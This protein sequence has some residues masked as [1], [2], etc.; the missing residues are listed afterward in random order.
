MDRRSVGRNLLDEAVFA[1]GLDDRAAEAL[2]GECHIRILSTDGLV[3]R[4]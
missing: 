1:V 4:G 2:D 3:R